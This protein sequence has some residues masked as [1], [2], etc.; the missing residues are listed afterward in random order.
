MGPLELSKDPYEV[1]R[2][3]GG[4][5]N[6]QGVTRPERF[7]SLFPLSVIDFLFSRVSRCSVDPRPTLDLGGKLRMSLPLTAMYDFS[8][9]RGEHREQRR[10]G[11]GSGSEHFQ[12]E[13][14]IMRQL[15]GKY[16]AGRRS[17]ESS[18]LD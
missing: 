9:L 8:L 2:F 13:R 6:E 17:R 7:Q 12:P 11:L 18:R 15:S 3:F 10:R 1:T 5:W 16:A 14:S 4:P